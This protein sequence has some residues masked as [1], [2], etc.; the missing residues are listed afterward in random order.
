MQ[1]EG[2]LEGRRGYSSP[3]NDPI[4]GVELGRVIEGVKDKRDQTEDVKMGRFGSGPPTEEDV[5]SDTEVD[6]SDKAE[7]QIDGSIFGLEDDLYVKFRRVFEVGGVR[8]WS[9]DGIGN[10][11]KGTTTEGFANKWGKTVRRPVIDADEDVAFSDTGALARGVERNMLRAE[12]SLRLDPPDAVGRNFEATLAL[13]VHS[14][15]DAS[16]HSR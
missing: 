7:S 14:C 12:A 15:E 16:D 6:Q 1:E 4:E 3:V 10:L 13:E 2:R 9:K 8:G 11:G 5:D